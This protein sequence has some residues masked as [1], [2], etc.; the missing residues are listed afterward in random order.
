MSFLST[1][2][3]PS[4]FFLFLLSHKYL[5]SPTPP[6]IYLSLFFFSSICQ[7]LHHYFP[8]FIFSV[9]VSFFPTPT[10]IH[11]LRYTPTP[12]SSIYRFHLF[13][14]LPFYPHFL[15]IP[16]HFSSSLISLPLPP[17]PS[18]TFSLSFSFSPSFLPPPSPSLPL[19]PFHLPSFSPL[20]SFP[21]ELW[22]SSRGSVC[23]ISNSALRKQDL[24]PV[25]DLKNR[26]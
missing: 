6:S 1:Y 16:H 24:V 7:S 2:L 13:C 20:S 8:L 10:L 21:T 11:L 14:T 4:V 25:E 5:P 15:Y 19:L 17:P 18:F 3:T 22:L 26:Y 23:P 12:P 9:T